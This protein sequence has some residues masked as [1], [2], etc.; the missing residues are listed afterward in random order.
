[1]EGAPQSYFDRLDA[2]I[3]FRWQ[4][5]PP[6]L[7]AACDVSPEATTVLLHRKGR[8][9]EGVGR[10]RSIRT[11]MAY[12]V[13]Q[14]YFDEL[15]ELEGLETLYVESLKATDLSAIARLTSLRRL[16]INGATRITDLA[17]VSYLPPSLGALAIENARS[18]SSLD[19]VESLTQI[20]ALAMEGSLDTSMRVATLDPIGTLTGL[21]HLFL[22]A[23]RAEDKRLQPLHSLTRLEVLEFGNYYAPGEVESL[24]KALPRTRCR[25][26][27][28]TAAPA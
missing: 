17:W 28:R 6:R 22:T 21:R 16:V 1:M 2:G 18:V 24:A 26:F 14:A 5:L 25:W 20:T 7:F 12:E 8:S 10:L 23:L 13:D 3:G 9:H 11:L 4:E 27:S 15:C 19:P